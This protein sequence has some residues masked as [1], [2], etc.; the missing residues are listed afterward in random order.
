VAPIISTIRGRRPPYDEVMRR[1]PA[2]VGVALVLAGCATVPDGAYYPER[3]PR[4][5]TLAHALYRAAEAAGDE[6]SR[7]SFAMIRTR[8]VMA[9]SGAEDGVFYFSDGL[10]AL[11]AAHLDTLVAREVAHEVLGHAGQRRALSIGLT[12]TFTVLGFVVPGLSVADWV[13]NPLIVRAFSREQEISADLRAVEILRAMGH[14]LPRR[15]LV[16]ALRD[17]EAINGKTPTGLLAT[18]P[19]LEDRLAAIGPVESL[20]EVA[21]TR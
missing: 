17:V 5:T 3:S 18:F 6:A 8:R 15:T 2:F 11:P 13:A 16:N 4:T 21:K 12:G 20:P 1:L 10:A 9:F 19:S 14:E 7:Y